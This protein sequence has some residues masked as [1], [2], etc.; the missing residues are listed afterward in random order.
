MAAGNV[1]SSITLFDTAHRFAVRRNIPGAH[2]DEEAEQAVIK[3]EFAKQSGP[4]AWILTSC[5]N[6]GVLKRWDTRGGTAAAAK[7]LIGESKGHRGGGDGGGI[8]GFVQGEGGKWVV[9]AG[10]E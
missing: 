7:G 4:G 1:D 10:D 6:D 3:V 5:G 8:L 2:E 9:T